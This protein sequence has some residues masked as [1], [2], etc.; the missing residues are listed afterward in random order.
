MVGAYLSTASKKAQKIMTA[1][2]RLTLN[3]RSPKEERGVYGASI[4][5]H[6]LQWSQ[7]NVNYLGV[8]ESP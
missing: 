5:V 2:E 6:T 3:V 1:L 4:W 8:G 7:R